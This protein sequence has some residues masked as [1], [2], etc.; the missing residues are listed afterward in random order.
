MHR[1]A[2]SPS[3]ETHP[4]GVVWREIEGGKNE[5]PPNWQTLCV[6]KVLDGL[7]SFFFFFPNMAAGKVHSIGFGPRGVWVCVKRG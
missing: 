3:C 5:I 4:S 2:C 1:R 6:E 7:A